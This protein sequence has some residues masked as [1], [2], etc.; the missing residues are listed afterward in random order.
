MRLNKFIS[1]TGVCSRC[2]AEAWIEPGRV[3]VNG[4]RTE[5]GTRA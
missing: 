4:R 5:L 1:E 2:A 3:S